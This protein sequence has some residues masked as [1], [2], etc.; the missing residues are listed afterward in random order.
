MMSVEQYMDWELARKTEVLAR[1]PA[2]V[3]LFPPQIL[4][5]VTWAR[6]RAAAVGSRWLFFLIGIVG[7]GV[8]LGP[9]GTAA[10]N[11]PTE[12]VPDHYDDG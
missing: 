5:D 8:Q 7:G 3:P 4:H 9:L 10:T 11:R 12:P 2:P 6:T 1:N